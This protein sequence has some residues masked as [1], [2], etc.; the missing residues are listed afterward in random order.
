MFLAHTTIVVKN[1]TTYPKKVTIEVVSG[2]VP[3]PAVTLC[4]MRGLDFYTIRK[5]IEVTRNNYTNEYK[6]AGAGPTT[7]ADRFVSAF[8]QY[9]VSHGESSSSPD[10]EFKHSSLSRTILSANINTNLLLEN[11]VLRDE[12]F[13]TCMFAGAK[14]NTVKEITTFFNQYFFSC[15][16]IHAPY[17][18]RS[19]LLTPSSTHRGEGEWLV[20]DRSVWKRYALR[21]LQEERAYCH[22]RFVRKKKC[23]VW[24][25]RSPRGAA[26]TWNSAFSFD[27]RIRCSDRILSFPRNKTQAQQAC[28]RSTRELSLGESVLFGPQ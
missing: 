9:M 8:S 14:C 27:R 5:I 21:R 6:T 23:D 7:P 4:N 1:Y 17:P 16:H 11:S 12:F 19:E 28:Q 3:F 22:S 26:S 20:G 24:K 13:V 15:F 18:E 10:K 25:R 2:G